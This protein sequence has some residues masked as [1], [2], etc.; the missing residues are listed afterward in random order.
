ML[1]PIGRAIRSLGGAAQGKSIMTDDFRLIRRTELETYVAAIFAA[2]GV[3]PPMAADWARMV[4]WANLRG[5]DSHGVLRVPRYVN[6]LKRKSINP[7]PAMRV[8]RSSGA[9]AVLEADRAPGAVAMAR[10]M[11]EA[12]GRA[13]EVHIGWCGARN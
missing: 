6:L 3:A 9:I 13:R 1:Y 8:E 10:A 11:T 5:V 7:K 4:V 2:A 12:I